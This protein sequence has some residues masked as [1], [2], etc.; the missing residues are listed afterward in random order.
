M[1]GRK[2]RINRKY[3]QGITVTD[4]HL[5]STS[6]TPLVKSPNSPS[7]RENDY[8]MGMMLLQA[9]AGQAGSTVH[10]CNL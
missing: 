8:I 6:R 5:V 1:S 3:Q 7:F 9:L 10:I 4:I 2:S